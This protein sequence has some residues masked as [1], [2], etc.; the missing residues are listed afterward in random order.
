MFKWIRGLFSSVPKGDLKS[1]KE[2]YAGAQKAW[3]T[4]WNKVPERGTVYVWHF[5]H[6]VL[7][8]ALY[9]AA[10]ARGDNILIWKP[11]Y[12]QALRLRLYRPANLPPKMRM[13]LDRADID[14]TDVM[15]WDPEL[16][17][18]HKEQCDPRCPWTTYKEAGSYHESG[19][20]FPGYNNL[21]HPADLLKSADR[22]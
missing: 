11:T 5:H 22:T 17:A 2:E 18:L 4:L 8:E 19:T 14:R 7:A 6:Q 1:I 15:N 13:L 10:S 9:D 3:G 16:A 20:I 21:D 12:E